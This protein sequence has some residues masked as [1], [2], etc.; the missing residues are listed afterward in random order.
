MKV[1]WNVLDSYYGDVF[2]LDLSDKGI[3]RFS[4]Q[5]GNCN[6]NKVMNDIVSF[7]DKG[8]RIKMNEGTLKRIISESIRKKRTVLKKSDIKKI[9]KDIVKTITEG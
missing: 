3:G 5:Y 2:Y 4:Q 1:L 8:A 9:V 7:Y 6:P